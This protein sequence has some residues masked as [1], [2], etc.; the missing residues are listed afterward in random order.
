MAEYNL[1]AFYCKGLGV[2]WQASIVVDR[3]L[4]IEREDSR[5]SLAGG[6][7]HPHKTPLS[8]KISLLF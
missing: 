3:E 6:W 2:S 8:K 7:P 1:D 4:T 5:N